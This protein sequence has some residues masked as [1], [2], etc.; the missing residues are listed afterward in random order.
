MRFYNT[1]HRY[2][3]GIDLHARSLFLVV[4]LALWDRAAGVRRTVGCGSP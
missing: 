1:Q 2:Y 4:P 3:C